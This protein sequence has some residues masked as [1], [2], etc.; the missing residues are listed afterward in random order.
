MMEEFNFAEKIFS[1]TLNRVLVG[2]LRALQ[3]ILKDRYNY[4]MYI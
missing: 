2:T 3:G 1:I 4:G